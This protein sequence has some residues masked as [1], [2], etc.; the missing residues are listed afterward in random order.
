MGRTQG[1]TD[2]RETGERGRSDGVRISAGKILKRIGE[3]RMVCENEMRKNG[4]KW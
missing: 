1:S 3:E 4:E 2:P